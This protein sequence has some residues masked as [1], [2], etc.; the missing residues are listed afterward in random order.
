MA[1]TPINPLDLNPERIEG[2]REYR[3]EARWRCQTDHLFLAP[4][5]G[6]TAFTE[7]IHRPVADFYVQKKPGLPLEEQDTCKKR[8]HLDPRHTF[9]TSMGRVDTTQW[10]LLDPD[11]TIV[12]E[13]ATQPLAYAMSDLVARQFLCPKSRIPSLFQKLFPEHVITSRSQD[14]YGTYKSPAR[15]FDQLDLTVNSMSVNTTQ[16]G[17]HPWIINPDDVVDTKNSGITA[18]AEA[19]QKVIE[20]HA[21]NVNLLRLGGYLHF[22]G[23][24]YHPFDLYGETLRKMDKD[25]WK[26]FIRQALTVKSGARLI[27]GKFPAEDEVELH[28]PKLL[29]YAHLRS[30]FYD[31][32]QAYMCQMMNDPQ[33]GAVIIFPETLYDQCQAVPEF[34]PVY[35]DVSVCWRMAF[36]G[37]SFMQR[38]AEGVACRYAGGRVYVLDAWRG[39]F[40]P[41]ELIETIARSCRDWSAKMLVLERVPGIE[42]ILPHLRNELIRR[43]QWLDIDQIDF[44][45]NDAERNNRMLQL[46]PMMR[47]GRLIF[48]RNMGCPQECKSQFVNHGLVANNGIIDA[49][50][51]LA[52][53]IP[54]SVIAD[55]V[56][57]HQRQMHEA[58]RGKAAYNF[59]YGSGGATVVEDAIRKAAAYAPKGN[60]YG[61]EPTMGGLDG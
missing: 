2:E 25:S 21:T 4:L 13:T 44:Q 7:E 19:R 48:S 32:Y 23:T 22:R 43:N 14:D 18:S 35:G 50:S 38:Y 41:S 3:E 30:L 15:T 61:L 8:M 51:R 46:E 37:K 1:V 10:I 9:K 26:V 47:S 27:E 5:L 31:N 6:M 34:I 52:L 60:S 36:D 29:S 17:W 11:V 53:R 33:G 54:V 56:S 58:S 39:S 12:N 57:D 16:S 42:Y 20:T 24:R 45:T 59:V 49:I 40:T 28:F 55:T